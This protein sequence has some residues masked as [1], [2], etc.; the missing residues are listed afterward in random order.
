MTPAT[1]TTK[2]LTAALLN[3]AM[4]FP[5]TIAPYCTPGVRTVTTSIAWLQGIVA[6]ARD[7]SL[8]V[9][10]AALS[11]PTGSYLCDRSKPCAYLT[12]GRN[13]VLP[14]FA[15]RSS[16]RCTLCRHAPG[17]ETGHAGNQT[18]TRCEERNK[19]ARTR[20]QNLQRLVADGYSRRR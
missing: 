3:V 16:R 11:S 19:M 12:G 1:T 14:E 10:I 13:E 7:S 15:F 9:P 18:G 4:G 8:H 6:L 5:P 20:R 2:P 17:R